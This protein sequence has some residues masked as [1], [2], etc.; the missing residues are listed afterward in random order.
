MKKVL[1]FIKEITIISCVTLIF[2]AWCV[3]YANEGEDNEYV[4]TMTPEW[5]K[6]VKDELRK[7]LGREPS[8][9]EIADYV[10]R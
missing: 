2:C 5:R 6:A 3:K 4:E 10:K 7:E 1:D 8:T 9:K